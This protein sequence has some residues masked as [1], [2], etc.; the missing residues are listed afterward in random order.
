MNFDAAFTILLGHEGSYS[1]H[2]S[3]PGGATMWGVTQAV[4][5]QNGYMGDMRDFTQAQA[6]LI[7]RSLY[8]DACRC[9][10][11]PEAVR[12]DVFDGA[13]NSGPGQSIRWLQ[14]SVDAEADG[15]IGA[16][17]LAA[18]RTLAGSM[19]KARYNGHRLF[20]MT[21]LK[22]WPAFGGGWARRV[23]SNLMGT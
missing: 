16:K 3:D 7:Y 8:W 22:T 12:F 6:K 11:L 21:N 18:C 17:T 14:R 1:N 13:V 20:F 23:A 10:E 19:I 4:A 9:E 5:R 2:K 15:V